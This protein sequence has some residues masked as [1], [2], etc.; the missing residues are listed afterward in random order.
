MYLTR[1]NAKADSAPFFV[2]YPA[3]NSTAA[4]WSAT[5]VPF[6]RQ[7]VTELAANYVIDPNRI[8][9]VKLGD[10]PGKGPSTAPI[11]IAEFSDFQ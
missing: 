11:T 10:A 6:I 5:D 2:V 1:L 3:G 4:A 9:T 7:T 8:Y